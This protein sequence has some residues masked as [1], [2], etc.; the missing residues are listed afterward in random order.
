M[1]FVRAFTVGSSRGCIVQVVTGSGDITRCPG[2][3]AISKTA[4]DGVMRVRVGV[5]EDRDTVK[6]GPDCDH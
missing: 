3:L 4:N 2:G 5:A 6:I 1:L